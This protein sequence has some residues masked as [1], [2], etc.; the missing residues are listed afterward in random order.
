V[1][2]KSTSCAELNGAARGTL[3]EALGIEILEVGA[4]FIRGRM[5]VDARTRQ[6]YGILHGGASVALAETLGSIAGNLS[7]EAGAGVVVGMEIN[8]NHLRAV[9]EGWVEGV[10]RPLHLGRS[11][12]VWEIRLH[13][14]GGRLS[15]VSRLTLA[16]VAQGG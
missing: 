12:Q 9:R 7:L 8:A 15:C 1:F 4:D 11:S 2:R 13:D 6:P 14:R 10:A 16:V 5:P 3:S